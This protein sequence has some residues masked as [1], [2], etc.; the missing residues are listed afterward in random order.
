[1]WTRNAENK[2]PNRRRSVAVQM[3]MSWLWV[4][5]GK[6]NKEA[7]K[8]CNPAAIQQGATPNIST[9]KRIAH[10]RMV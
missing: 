4:Q 7:A 5:N 10:R 3:A 6:L 8:L 2:I 1:M 9:K